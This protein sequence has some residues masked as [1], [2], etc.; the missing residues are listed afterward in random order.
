M[1]VPLM[2]IRQDAPA[3]SGG[4]YMDGHLMLAGQFNGHFKNNRMQQTTGR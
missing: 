2:E 1:V 3:D 4:H